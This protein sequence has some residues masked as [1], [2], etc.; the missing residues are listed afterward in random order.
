MVPI[1]IG[2]NANK[3]IPNKVLSILQLD[4]QIN[5]FILNNKL[6]YILNIY[7]NKIYN[8]IENKYK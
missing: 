3:P 5:I 2:S 6:L 1:A 4:S 8:T 7:N